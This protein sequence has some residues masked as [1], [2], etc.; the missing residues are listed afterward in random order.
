MPAQAQ[1][2]GLTWCRP[3]LQQPREA[4]DVYVRRYRLRFID[5]TSNTDPRFARNRLRLQ[6]WPALTGAFA[7]AETA[8]LAAAAHAQQAQALAAEVAAAD[9]QPL[10]VPQTGEHPGLLLAA[11][12][13]LSAARRSNVLRFW[14][15]Q[16]LGQGAPE[17]LVQRLL[18]D[19]APSDE[20]GVRSGARWPGP[21]VE[22]RL[23]QGVLASFAATAARPDA[24][25]LQQPPLTLD[26]SQPGLW[27][28]PGWAGS[29]EVMRVAAEGA[30]MFVLQKVCLRQRAG[31]ERFAT[32]AAAT[33]RSLKKQYQSAGIAAWQ[34][35]GPLV[36][37]TDQRLLFVPA[38][39]IDARCH[40]QADQP[41]CS[42]RWV[43]NQGS[44]P[45]G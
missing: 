37:T 2:G 29:M 22:L 30:P 36:W 8:L 16:V 31:G 17:T 40:A 28:V 12:Q 1:R 9:L 34:R 38:L 3:W 42:L 15:R 41:Q 39:G 5:D 10:L 7:D 32:Q 35:Q 24:E 45:L 26:L 19:L 18:H 44:L 20:A 23:H 4:I 27:P 43:P 14:L 11:W 25:S 13:T 33:P 6:V 21:G